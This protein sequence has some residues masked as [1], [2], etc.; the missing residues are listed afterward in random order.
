MFYSI[1]GNKFQNHREKMVNTND[2]IKKVNVSTKAKAKAKAKDK[3]LDKFNLSKKYSSG[4]DCDKKYIAPFDR[5]TNVSLNNCA[6]E[7][8]NNNNCKRFSF[9]KKNALGAKG[10]SCRIS[11]EG[12]C[13]I[14]VDKYKNTV[15][16]GKKLDWDHTKYGYNYWG[17]KVYDLIQEDDE[18]PKTDTSYIPNISE[19]PKT[20]SSSTS[21]T[22]I[23]NGKVVKSISKTIKMVNGKLVTQ[24]EQQE[25]EDK[26]EDYTIYITVII[27]AAILGTSIYFLRGDQNTN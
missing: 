10:L 11:T 9:G 21:S 19:P 12:L 27:V 14:T 7:C 4:G 15:S 20:T 8:L 24:E 26:P 13:P 5:N 23:V 2:S 17:G 3:A 6:I 22:Q 16:Q 1:S 18:I 25:Q